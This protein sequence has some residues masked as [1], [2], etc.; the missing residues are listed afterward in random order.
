[1]IAVAITAVLAALAPRVAQAA[2]P[3]NDDF[4]QAV[5]ITAL[6]FGA[7]A[8]LAEAT[9]AEDDPLCTTSDEASVWYDYTAGSD[10]VLA[11]DLVGSG[12]GFVAVYTGS[13]GALERAPDTGCSS[14]WD[15]PALLRV[16]AG[17][18]YHFMV[19]VGGWWSG[20]IRLTVDELLPP[21]ND[22]FADA[23]PISTVPATV[24][25][26]LGAATG[27]PG[28]PDPTCDGIT[29]RLI[30]SAW[31]AFTAPRSESI[32]LDQPYDHQSAVAVYTGDSFGALTEVYCANHYRGVLAVT[33]GQ[34]YR[35]QVAYWSP[36]AGDTL[37]ELDV[38][39][40]LTAH[41][42]LSIPDPSTLDTVSFSDYTHDEAGQP[43]TRT[44]WDFGDG[45]AATGRDV[46]HR[47]AADGDYVVRMT[48]TSADGRTAATSRTVVVRTHDVRI[49]SFTVP[50]RGRPGKTKAVEVAVTNQ[51]IPEHATVTLYRSTPGGFTEIARA[52]QYVPARTVAFPFN[53][54][55]T[56]EDAA[57]GRVT[58]RAVVT[59]AAGVRD[60]R[61]IDNEAVAPAT[62]VLPAVS[63][64]VR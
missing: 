43:I 30:P 23:T 35:V 57:V 5:A 10:G 64:S 13:R 49:A 36:G 63:E 19:V 7:D 61:P 33:A 12:Y 50:V 29:G 16:T 18:T 46:D 44:E 21:A 31:F 27:E 42:G 53:Y 37:L 1:M 6:P 28:E 3:A 17:T 55:F 32:T 39:P 47:F 4:D 9:P 48:A 26:R 54:T 14:G 34:T 62:T 41:I 51:R 58:F 56:P 40:P 60:A 11:F 45:T 25:T 15:D 2:P 8:D 20:S 22:H 59:L 24:D 52:T 38:A